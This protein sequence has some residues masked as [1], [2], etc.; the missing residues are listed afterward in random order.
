MQISVPSPRAT[1]EVVAFSRPLTVLVLAPTLHAGAADAGAVDLVR[2]LRGA[3]HRVLVASNGGRLEDEVA[4]AGGEFIRLDG[5]DFNPVFIAR[6]A[7]ALT[8]VVR[9]QRCDVI[10]AHGRAAAWAG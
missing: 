3:G 9:R 8:R 4:E 10:H 7:V 6:A 5:A 2:I 1:G